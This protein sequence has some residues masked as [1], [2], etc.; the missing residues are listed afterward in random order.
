M[1]FICLFFRFDHFFWPGMFL[2]AA[3]PLLLLMLLPPVLRLLRLRRLRLLRLLRLLLLL[4]VLLPP[5]LLPPVPLPVLLP[6]LLPGLRPVLLRDDINALQLETVEKAV[7]VNETSFGGAAPDIATHNPAVLGEFG[8][9]AAPQT[10]HKRLMALD[11]P[12]DAPR[13]PP[14]EKKQISV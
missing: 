8:V 11:F 6:V 1:R 14:A 4:P 5:V 10:F 3:R 9:A 13:T 2:A 12:A 7:E